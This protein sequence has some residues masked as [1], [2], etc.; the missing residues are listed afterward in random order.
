MSDIKERL[1]A[2]YDGEL[3]SNDI[4]S[5]LEELE[6]DN[7]LQKTLSLYSLIGLSLANEN[8]V[9]DINDF[10]V[11]KNKNIFTNIW[12]S[13]TLT[14]AASIIL[15]L[16]VVNYADF[17][18]MNI[19]VDSTNKIASAVSSR[20]AKEIISNSDEYLV[21]HIMS[22][23]NDPS[24]MNSNTIDLKNVGYAAGR[25]G[26]IG[27]SNG[28][29]KFQL[30]IENKN[31]GLK[32]IRYWKHGNKMIYIVPISNGRVVTLYGNLSASSAIEIANSI[33]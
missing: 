13:N 4:D 19:S 33:N 24:F 26:N 11:E 3:D 16:F 6:A 20:E 22:V 25:A 17:S 8:K 9:T 14:A 23:I 29:E 7:N 2:L 15:T 31:F 10:K 1:S 21:D 12:L 27:Y 18:R 30:R 5:V 28:N 32:K